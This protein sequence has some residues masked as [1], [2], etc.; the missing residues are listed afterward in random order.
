MQSAVL[1]LRDDIQVYIIDNTRGGIH[2][3]ENGTWQI[4][5][6]DKFDILERGVPKFKEL[7]V[8]FSLP[9]TA[10]PFNGKTIYL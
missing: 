6:Y 10:Y 1:V 3:K 4:K 7:K 8:K 9:I 2:L 5:G